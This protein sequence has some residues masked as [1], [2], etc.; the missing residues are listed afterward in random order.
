[1]DK[2]QRTVRL[3]ACEVFKPAVGFLDVERRY[4]HVGVTYLPSDLHLRP[5][6]LKKRVLKEMAKARDNGERAVCLYGDCF[7]DIEECCRMHQ[8]EK[9]P[10]HFCYEMLLGP[11]RFKKLLDEIAGT[12][13][14]EQDVIQHFEAYCTNPLELQDEEIRR[15]CFENYRRLMYIKQPEDADLESRACDI[16]EFL[17][18]HLEVSDADYSYLQDKLTALL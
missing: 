12:Y 11:E 17:E 16:A 2:R 9:V 4:P 14:V 18:L 3:I 7:P 1:M 6:N 8:A 5:Q 15:C 10:G 13:F